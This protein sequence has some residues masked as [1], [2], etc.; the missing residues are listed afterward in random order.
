MVFSFLSQSFLT[1]LV[2]FVLLIFSICSLGSF[3]FLIFYARDI[4]KQARIDREKFLTL[5]KVTQQKI[6]GVLV[7]LQTIST[8]SP[9]LGLFG[10]IAGLIDVFTNIGAQS[11]VDIAVIAPGISDALLTTLAGLCVAIPALLFYQYGD[12]LADVIE[13]LYE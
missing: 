2:Y 9:L 4:K 5:Q 7:L 1:Q 13:G 10:T 11:S 12:Y 8:V 6:D 3:L